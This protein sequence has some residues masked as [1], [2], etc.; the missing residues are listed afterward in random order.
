MVCASSEKTWKEDGAGTSQGCFRSN[1]PTGVH[2]HKLKP[3]LKIYVFQEALTLSS[4][5]LKVFYFSPKKKLKGEKKKKQRKT[6]MCF[7]LQNLLSH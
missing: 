4:N 6:K 7:D 3:D 2:R 5:V 1:L